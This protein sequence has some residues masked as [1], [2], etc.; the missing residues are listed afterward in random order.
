[1]KFNVLGRSLIL[2]IAAIIF[3]ACEEFV[4]DPPAENELLDGPI[5]GL[6]H[7]NQKRF[8]A[9]DEA[10][11]RSFSAD[12]GL[13]PAFVANSCGTSSIT[14]PTEFKRSKKSPLFL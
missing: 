2:I 6:S 13:G 14:L 12:E 8:V 9:G 1:M 11:N 7:A 10:F 5:A 4:T 3:I